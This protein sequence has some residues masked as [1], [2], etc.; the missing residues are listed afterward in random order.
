MTGSKLD[1]QPMLMLHPAI[2]VT[3]FTY[4]LFCGVAACTVQFTGSPDQVAEILI[5]LTQREN[6]A[7]REAQE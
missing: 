4:D 2:S 7:A 3:S 5:Y 1:T 6:E